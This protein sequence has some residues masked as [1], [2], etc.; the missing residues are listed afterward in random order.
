MAHEQQEVIDLLMK[1]E[2]HDGD[3]VERI[4]THS[5]IVFLAGPRAF[6]L[7]RAVK[8]DYL[9]FSTP[10]LR[11]AAC[12]AEARINRRSAPAIYRGVVAVTRNAD[13]ALALGGPGAAVE[14]LVE[15]SRFDQ[16]ALL[17][18]L[19]ARG[20]LDLGL[21]RPLAAAVAAFHRTAPHRADH[22]GLAGMTWVV[23]GNDEGFAQ[24]GA[25]LLDPALC[26]EL[27]ERSRA[28]LACHGALLEQRRLDGFVRQCH[29]DLHLRN[30]VLLDGRPTLFDAIE[31]NDEIACADVWYDLAFLLMDLWHR[32]LPRHANAVFN[33]Y[34]A[35]TGDLE[36]LALLPLFLASRA[37]V[38]AKTSATAAR[39]QPDAAHTREL[40]TLAREYLAMGA[41]LLRPEPARLIAVGGLSGSGK[42]TVALS[43]AP[44]VGAVPGALV[45][46]TDEIRKALCGVQPL[47]RLGPAGYTTDITARVYGTL[48]DRA[49]TALKGGHSV[50]VD[51]VF[52]RPG[53]REALEQAAGAAGVP[54]TGLWLDAP[55]EVLIARTAQRRLDP[56]DADPAVVRQQLSA[57]AGSVRW[58]RID[59]GRPEAAVLSGVLAEVSRLAAAR[60]LSAIG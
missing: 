33:G 34:A 10:E 16:E 40:E 51:A 20:A 17:D 28:A 18:R 48:A 31:F 37:A 32:Q 55:A 41:A 36:G 49:A 60:R 23:N 24:Q 8:F 14:W 9:D 22:G 54:F 45:L 56:S 58:R 13:G 11:Q 25:G 7:K 15:M 4:D 29:G 35:E 57:G 39:V 43:L 38:R 59:A 44:H 19:A 30:I 5:A 50:I 6:K 12:E 26:H 21:M 2:T 47:E 1:P 53:D 46:R 52:A 42:S 3:A 27:T